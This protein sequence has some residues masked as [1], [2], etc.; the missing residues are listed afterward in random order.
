[1]YALTT[2]ELCDYRRQLESSIAFYDKNHPAAPV[3]GDLQAALDA[4]LAEQESR[5]KIARG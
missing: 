4:V 2:S 5:K 1:L 3:R